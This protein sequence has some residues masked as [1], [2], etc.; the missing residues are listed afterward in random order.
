MTHHTRKP[1][2]ARVE[3]DISTQKEQTIV[4]IDIKTHDMTVTQSPRAEGPTFNPKNIVKRDE[5][6]VSNSAIQT[7]ALKRT[8]PANKEK[9]NRANNQAIIQH[10]IKRFTL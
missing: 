3:H 4:T 5:S 10:V 6:A 7:A 1:H 2:R 9:T 8:T